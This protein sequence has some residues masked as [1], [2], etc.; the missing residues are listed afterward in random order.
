M[1][2]GSAQF[3]ALRATR[4]VCGLGRCW[5]ESSYKLIE[6]S[7]RAGWQTRLYWA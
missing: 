2:A 3:D 4:G 6:E 7:T 1:S 5:T